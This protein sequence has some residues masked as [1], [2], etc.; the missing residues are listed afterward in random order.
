MVLFAVLN[1]ANC[2]P[3]WCHFLF[4]LTSQVRVS[5]GVHS[6]THQKDSRRAQEDSWTAQE[7][8]RTRQEESRPQNTTTDRHPKGKSKE[9]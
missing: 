8:S 2:Y 1:T 6:K 5:Q 9:H 7:D 4:R 3:N